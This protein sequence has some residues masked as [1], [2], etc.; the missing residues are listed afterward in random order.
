ME[1]DVQLVM[2]LANCT[3]EIAKSAYEDNQGDV[4]L[5]IDSI[6]FGTL[7]P[8]KKR[9]RED[10]NEH[11]AYLNSIRCTMEHIDEDINNHRSTTTNPLEPVESDEMQDRREEM[12]PQNNYLQECQIPA[13]EEA[14]QIPETVCPQLPAHSCDLR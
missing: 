5:A 1:K 11:E 9:R 14:A 3:E 7:V 12:V 8:S 6:L 2:N 13:M 10:I 4:L